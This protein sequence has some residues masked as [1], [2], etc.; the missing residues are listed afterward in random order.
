MYLKNSSTKAEKD[1]DVLKIQ[2]RLSSCFWGGINHN[3]LYKPKSCIN[4][5]T[6]NIKKGGWGGGEKK[7]PTGGVIKCKINEEYK[8]SRGP[9][10]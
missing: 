5:W 2:T 10:F 4:I 1:P 7:D 6:N 9:H 8:D 3:H